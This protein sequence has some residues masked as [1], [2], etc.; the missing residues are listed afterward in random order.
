V[1]IPARSIAARAADCAELDRSQARKR[2]IEFAERRA[3][4]AKNHR[5]L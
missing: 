5:T 2:A 1:D 4:S 3:C